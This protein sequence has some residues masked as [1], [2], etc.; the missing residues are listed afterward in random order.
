MKTQTK[1][2]IATFFT[3]CLVLSTSLQSAKSITSSFSGLSLD[4]I[5]PPDLLNPGREATGTI[6]PNGVPKEPPSRVEA[7]ESC[8][9]DLTQTYT[10]TGTL[11]GMFEINFRIIVHGPCTEPPG[12]YDEEW[13]AYGIFSGILNNTQTDGKFTYIAKV[14]EGGNIDGKI[15]FGQGISGEL[16]VKGNFKDGKLSYNGTID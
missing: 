5:Q 14:G 3:L 2:V 10:V 6:K 12:T 8:I 7:G 15:V 1:N 9:V 11:S 4:L 16:K 13:I